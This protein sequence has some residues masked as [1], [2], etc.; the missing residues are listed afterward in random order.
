MYLFLDK[1]KITQN[2]V[3]PNMKHHTISDASKMEW[4]RAYAEAHLELREYQKDI[5]NSYYKKESKRI[6]S[7]IDPYGEENWEE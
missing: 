2:W 3:D 5:L 1:E 6:Y 7:D 4:M